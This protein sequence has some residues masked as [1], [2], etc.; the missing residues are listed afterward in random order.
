MLDRDSIAIHNDWIFL[1]QYLPILVVVRKPNFWVWWRWWGEIQTTKARRQQQ[2][3]NKDDKNYEKK[4]IMDWSRSPVHCALYCERYILHT[5]LTPLIHLAL[6]PSFQ[7]PNHHIVLQSIQ[8][9]FN[10]HFSRSLCFEKHTDWLTDWLTKH[11][12]LNDWLNQFQTLKPINKITRCA[13]ECFFL[14]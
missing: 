9:I 3:K 6:Q 5:H 2:H 13:S 14:L 1:L 4:S 8:I 11:Y 10:A 7:Q 12:R